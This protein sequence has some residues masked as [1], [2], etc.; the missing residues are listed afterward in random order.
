MPLLKK[1]LATL[2]L[3]GLALVASIEPALAAD[4]ADVFSVGGKALVIAIATVVIIF[5]SVF[6]TLF[7]VLVGQ[8]MGSTFILDAGMGEVL[9]LVWIVTRDFTNIAIM[10][11]FLAVAF[12]VVLGWGDEQGGIAFLKKVFPK[13]I[14][15]LVAVNFTWTGASLVLST[16]D[17]LATAVFSLP[18]AVWHGE[19]RGLPCPEASVSGKPRTADCLYEI[20]E[21][22]KEHTTGQAAGETAGG[23]TFKKMGSFIQKIYDSGDEM[24]TSWLDRENFALAMLSNMLDLKSIISLNASTNTFFGTLVATLGA[25]ITTVITTLVFFFLLVTLVV[26]MVMLWFLIAV[27]PLGIAAKIMQDVVN[28]PFLAENDWGKA[29]LQQAFFPLLAAFPLSIGMIMIFAGNSMTTLSSTSADAITAALSGDVYALLWWG[30][31]I[32]V[33][34]VGTKKVI[35]QSSPIAD[36]L[37]NSVYEGVNGFGKAAIGSIKYAPIV[38]VPTGKGMGALSFNALKTIP[39]A[40]SSRLDSKTAAIGRGIGAGIADGIRPDLADIDHTKDL[41]EKIVSEFSSSSTGKDVARVLQ[42]QVNAGMGHEGTISQEAIARL[43][44]TALSKANLKD[45]SY[46][47]E[48]FLQ[49]KGVRDAIGVSTANSLMDKFRENGE[50]AKDGKSST[51]DTKDAATGKAGAGTDTGASARV[52][53][54]VAV[55]AIITKLD[56]VPDGSTASAH[57]ERVL[58]ELRAAGVKSYKAL[59]DKGK[60]EF[61]AKV[62][63]IKAGTKSEE[64]AEKLEELLDSF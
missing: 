48:E 58:D 1:A 28:I 4:I 3:L 20:T 21:T 47:V 17:V 40:V 53:D 32:G 31:A 61:D 35:A 8:L 30:A 52:V 25:M 7:A 19:V 24:A 45:R 27:A 64:D 10:F 44:N 39:T 55:S 34:W 16:N 41:Q 62:Y 43:R 6:A 60:N 42:E 49:H 38:P 50:A 26:R 15:T 36:G 59:D 13:M 56:A 9:K 54:A 22:L 12:C 51:G 57:L 63:K 29:F 33:I 18:Q 14:L 2:P 37:V 11:G 46:S 5:C 23:T